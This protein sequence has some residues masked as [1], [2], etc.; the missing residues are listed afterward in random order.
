ME[1]HLEAEVPDGHDGN[2]I[3]SQ[4][5]GIPCCNDRQPGGIPKRTLRTFLPKLAEALSRLV[6]RTSSELDL[7]REGSSI[8]RV[9]DGIDL[10]TRR[11]T[12]VK[13][14]RLVMLGKNPEVSKDKVF[15]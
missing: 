9:N 13:D 6:Y 11:V 7:H 5:T 2:T 3:F 1:G 15:E 8:G 12:E 14:L 4:V 10:V